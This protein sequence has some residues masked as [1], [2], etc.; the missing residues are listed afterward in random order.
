MQAIPTLNHYIDSEDPD[1]QVEINIQLPPLIPGQYFISVWVGSHNT[2]TLDFIKE[3]V[4][5]EIY[6]SPIEGRIF[7]HALD[8]GHIVPLSTVKRVKHNLLEIN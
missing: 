5:F 4:V 8:H 7:P 3:A 1:H 6:D 2:E